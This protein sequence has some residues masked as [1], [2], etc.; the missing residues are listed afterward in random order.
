[1]TKPKICKV[2]CCGKPARHLGFCRAH[3]RR[4]N[5][6]GDPLAGGPHHFSDPKDALAARSVKNPLTGCIEWTGSSESKGYG[7]IRIDGKLVKAHRFAWEIANGPIPAGMLVLHSCDNPRCVNPDHL[8]VGTHVDNMADMDARNRRV[9]NQNKGVD[10]PAAKITE[11]DVRAIRQD[12]RRQID[13]A[14]DYGISQPVVSKIK[15]KQAWKH[16]K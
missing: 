13:I 1:M 12:T 6:Y 5:R 14:K 10:C 7:Q 4:F 15:L 8:R 9:N 16:V 3:Y 2:E 11:D